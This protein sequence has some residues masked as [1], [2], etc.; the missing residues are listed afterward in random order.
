FIVLSGYCIHRTGLRT[1]TDEK[2]Y[3][4]IRRA[5]R[6][7]PVYFMA[8]LFGIFLF[9][10]AVSLAP[11]MART[12]SGTQSIAP[13]C[14]AAKITTLSALIT[15]FH[16]CSFVVNAP[17]GTV[18]V[19]V[20]LYAVYPLLLILL[21]RGRARLAFGLIAASFIATCFLGMFGDALG[22]NYN[23]LQNTSLVG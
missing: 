23:W 7:L 21:W 22:V 19:E 11:D 6:I 17:L 1:L 13:L 15:S 9:N 14:V 2:K 12:L 10:Y 3:Y 18:M 20:L 4:F 8:T 5:F 16:P